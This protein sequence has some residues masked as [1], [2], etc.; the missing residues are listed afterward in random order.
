VAIRDVFLQI[1]EILGYSPVDPQPM[2]MQFRRDC[3]RNAG[4]EDGT[5]PDSE[6]NARRLN[7]IVYRE[8]LDSNYLIPKPDKLILTDVN[9]PVFS[10]RVPGTVIYTKPG[11]RLR[12]HVRNADSIS[13]SFHLHGLRYG[14]D[15]DGAWPFG[16]QTSDSRRSD[17]ICPGQN[18]TYHFD[19]TDEMIGA[20]PFHDHC[21]NIAD[22]INRGLFG[23]VVVLPKEGCEYPTMM[24]L[25]PLIAEFLKERG[26]E[27]KRHTH[28]LPPA[29]PMAMS[30]G[31]S[32][33]MA[34]GGAHGAQTVSMDLDVDARRMFLEEY[35][36]LEYAQ[37]KP[38]RED[39][40]HVPV[41]LHFMSG[42][43][44]TPAFDS[45]PLAPGATFDVTFGAEGTYNYHCNIHP[46]MQAKVV[47]AMGNPA[48][49]TV[50]ILSNPTMKFDP[51]TVSVAPGGKVTW[52]N[53]GPLQHTVTEDAG[54]LPSYCLNG[55]TFVGNTPTI[56][57]HSGQKIRW[58]VFNLDLGM[59]WHNFHP[60]S[61]RWH[62]AGEAYD[63]RSIGPAESFVLETTAPPALL[64]PDDIAK[65]QDPKHRPKE[66]HPYKLR[67]DF[68][69]HC[70][71]EMHMMSGLAGLVRSEETVWLTPAQVK[72]LE[73]TVG[74]PLDPGNNECPKVDYTRCETLGCGKWEEVSGIPEVTM[75]HA[76]LLPQT[77]KVLYWGYGDTRD[78]L[79]RLW[80]YTTP[81]GVLSSP[82][83]QPFDVTNPVH[84]RPL[85]NIWSAEHAYIDEA[86]GTLLIHG[87]FTPK[88]SFKF[89]PG[90]LQ[91][92]LTAATADERFYSTSLTLQDGKILTMYGS[93]SKTLE[94]YDPI[95]NLWSA[96]KAF[97]A[98]FIY[99]Y[100]P[101]A[102]VLPG[103][104]IFI[105]G[106]Q[107]VTHRFD[108]TANPIVDDPAKT[109]MTIAGNRSTVGE[110]GTSVL[111]PLRPPH[112][113]ARV[114]IAGG[115]P[116]PAQQTAEMIDFSLPTPAW[117][118]LPNLNRPRALQVNSVLLPDGRVFLAG[119][120]DG[121]DGGPTEIFDPS[122]PAAGWELCATMKHPRG[123]HSSAI[124]LA[125]G[126][127]LMGGDRPNAWKSGET[128]P[129]ERYFPSYYFMAR[130]VI[131]SVSSPAAHGATITIQT[132]NAASIAEVVLL[133]PGAVTHG[134]NMSQRFVGCAIVG[135][136]ATSVKAKM[137]PDGTIAPPGY[138]LLFIVNGSR[139]PSVANWIQLTP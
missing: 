33:P 87:G 43:D 76:T 79:S 14:I 44:G 60:H 81:G 107:G 25:P 20:W 41:F 67:G 21:H 89:H 47:V 102:Y 103:G 5:I 17:E 10:Y 2:P 71:V 3:M 24:E 136:D 54:G 40:L 42:S 122:N 57:A 130:P 15:S 31:A 38:K 112:Y 58:Y 1:E 61:Q 88:Q 7:A 133:R 66:A 109:W 92:S 90:T 62:F 36:R 11:E 93:A 110:K 106:H 22:N 46:N 51:D 123:Y 129:S 53:V 6:V 64:L 105:A 101:W 126:S 95:T 104:D 32:A 28:S 119:G 73:A 39:T 29:P 12:I 121:P 108:W 77:L 74:L 131:S 27:G 124:L 8:Y 4:H 127:V 139:V 9:E 132:P 19:V 75:M 138:Y 56:V 128:L 16:T 30:T 83:N 72:E 134:F 55:R 52:T 23:G 111:L 116:V 115:D 86:D 98:T 49:A 65:T 82:A 117:K 85:A 125:D 96:P 70:H 63:T 35:A 80:D 100:Y 68:L 113:E 48:I 78:D 69:F 18:W 99:V 97:P 120:I 45:G 37:P 34:M 50:N 114:L 137:P 26:K 135:G 59:V 91:W 118:S 13:H 84:N 94:S